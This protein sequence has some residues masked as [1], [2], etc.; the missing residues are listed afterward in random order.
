MNEETQR[1]VKLLRRIKVVLDRLMSDPL[2]AAEIRLNELYDHLRRD[3][4]IHEEIPSS[5]A[6]SQFLRAMHQQGLMKQMIPNYRV[7]TFTHE[8]YQWYF[9]RGSGQGPSTAPSVMAVAE[10]KAA[11]L[12]D[13]ATFLATWL[14]FVEHAD[15]AANWNARNWTELTIGRPL[16]AGEG[17]PFGDLA[18]R[19]GGG[20]WRYWKED[21]QF[22][23]VLTEQPD[24][25]LAAPPAGWK[26]FYPAVPDIVVEQELNPST[27]WWEMGKLIRS[28]ARLKVLL[29]YT[30]DEAAAMDLAADLTSLLS[31]ASA[32]HPEADAT[33]YML[34]VGL[35]P[36]AWRT[37]V[38]TASG[39]RTLLP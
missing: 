32:L 13:P 21:Q 18:V 4:V 29:T 5:R 10:R 8:N 3:P 16:S 36:T 28:R 19:H 2:T 39:E 6:M 35:A 34:V 23:L 22:D 24:H 7:D 1:Q 30:E 12:T 25:V 37:W 17:S 33:R 31:Q 20:N 26:R 9:F 14:A 11:H 38:F 27:C 15:L